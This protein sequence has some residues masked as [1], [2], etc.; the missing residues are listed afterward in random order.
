MPMSVCNMS[1]YAYE[2]VCLRVCMPMS[3]C[4]MSVYAYECMPMSV[5]AYECMQYECVCL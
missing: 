5:Y 1:V 4:N 3:V 2:C